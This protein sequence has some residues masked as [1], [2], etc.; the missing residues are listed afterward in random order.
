MP[1]KPV[2]LLDSE[3]GKRITR[4]FRDDVLSLYFSSSD[5]DR[6]EKLMLSRAKV[7]MEADSSL[8]LATAI[9]RCMAEWKQSGSPDIEK[10]RERYRFSRPLNMLLGTSPT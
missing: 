1:R 9:H 6:A 5:L 3:K 2:R 4:I 10:E 7:L 8:H